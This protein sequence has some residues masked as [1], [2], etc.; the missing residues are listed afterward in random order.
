MGVQP[1]IIKWSTEHAGKHAQHIPE[2]ACSNIETSI[3]NILV[4]LKFAI[5]LADAAIK[6]WQQNGE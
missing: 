5:H 1:I 3:I 6:R 2:Q 4:Y